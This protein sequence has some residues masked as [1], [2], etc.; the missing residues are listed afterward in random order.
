MSNLDKRNLGIRGFQ[1]GGIV[2]ASKGNEIDK[3]TN[4][5]SGRG[6]VG[7]IQGMVNEN[8]LGKDTQNPNGDRKRDDRNVGRMLDAKSQL[9]SRLALLQSDGGENE[10]YEDIISRNIRIATGKTEI[11]PFML[12]VATHPYF[13]DAVLNDDPRSSKE[14]EAEIKPMIAKY[15]DELYQANKAPFLSRRDAVKSAPSERTA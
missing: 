7:D 8:T 12:R 13:R 9:Y 2:Y 6:L 3:E 4:W 1:K 14:L 15:V 11:D 10:S 5:R